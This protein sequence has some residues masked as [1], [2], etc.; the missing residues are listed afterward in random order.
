MPLQGQWRNDVFNEWSTIVNCSADI[1]DGLWING[2]PAAVNHQGLEIWTGIRSHQ[3]LSS[4]AA[5]LFELIE[6]TERKPVNC[7][8]LYKLSFNICYIWELKSTISVISS[9][10]FALA[11]LPIPK[12]EEPEFASDTLC[13]A[14]DASSSQHAHLPWLLTQRHICESGSA[15]ESCAVGDD[16]EGKQNTR[17]QSQMTSKE[18]RLE[19]DQHLIKNSKTLQGQYMLMVHE[20]TMPPFLGQ[21]LTPAFKLLKFSRGNQ[22]QEQ[23]FFPSHQQLKRIKPHSQG[24]YLEAH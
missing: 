1:C 16:T 23:R 7:C 15:D 4:S 14:G 18:Q 3:N 12:G 19:K 21:T 13:G 8:V 20:V 22:N 5:N 6:E 10:G 17:E 9:S 2:Y 24:S 11:D